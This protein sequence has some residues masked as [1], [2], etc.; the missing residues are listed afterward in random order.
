MRMTL[1]PDDKQCLAVLPARTRHS[2]CVE[3]VS[4]AASMAHKEPG[5]K[6]GHAAG[7]A[8]ALHPQLGVP[9]AAV[10]SLRTEPMPLGRVWSVLLPCKELPDPVGAHGG[11]EWELTSTF[12]MLVIRAKAATA[13]CT[14]ERP[15][16]PV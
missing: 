2:V 12:S 11:P 4:L 5:W 7:H 6:A 16:A 8:S 15:H 13:T 10:N 9:R 14:R 1:D 3:L